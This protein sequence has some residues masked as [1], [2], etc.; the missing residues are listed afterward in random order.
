M[1]F[2]SKD[3]LFIICC[4]SILFISIFTLC[5]YLFPY[6]GLRYDSEAFYPVVSEHSLIELNENTTVSQNFNSEN[7]HLKG[8]KYYVIKGESEITGSLHVSIMDNDRNLILDREVPFTDIQN[9][10][11]YSDYF[12]LTLK[13]IIY[14]E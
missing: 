12:S 10:E 13:K 11:W 5:Y 4:I 14:I 3:K 2:N 7:I 6:Q 8:L 9:A 1:K